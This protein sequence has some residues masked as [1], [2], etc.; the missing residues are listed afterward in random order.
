MNES[1]DMNLSIEL[2]FFKIE[3]YVDC[4]AVSEVLF[5]TKQIMR[6]VFNVIQKMDMRYDDC[7]QLKCH[8]ITM[9]LEQFQVCA[10]LDSK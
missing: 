10:C 3:D 6:A 9:K 8:P 5:A 2:F 4:E 1:C 7:N